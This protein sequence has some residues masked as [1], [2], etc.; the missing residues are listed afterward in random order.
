VYAKPHARL[1]LTEASPVG[2]AF[3]AYARD[4]LACEQWLQERHDPAAFPVTIVRPSHTYSRRWLPN[5]VASGSY[6]LGARFEQGKPVFVHG[7]GQG[8]WTLTATADFAVAL[9]GLAGQAGA[10]GETYQ[11]TSD[12]VLTWNQIL[13]ETAWALGVDDPEIITVPTDFICDVVPGMTDKLKGDKAE[14]GV[15][16]N[17]KIKRAVREF[18]GTTSFREG[19]AKSVK[20]FRADPVRMTVDPETDR[21]FDRVVEAWRER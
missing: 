10:I 18:S 8:L 13:R 7:D 17:A 3:S 4:K 16:D 15:F 6:T 21:V 2:N 19:I 14:P 1:P 20:W 11:V 12:E 5:P 9:A